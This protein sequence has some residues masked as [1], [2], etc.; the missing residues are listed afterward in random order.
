M[1]KGDGKH[2]VVATTPERSVQVAVA[3]YGTALPHELAHFVVERALGL[4][5]GF[6][7][8]LAAGADFAAV[9]A[10]NARSPKTVQAPTDPLV[11]AHLDELL[12]AERLVAELYQLG[13]GA[14]D[15]HGVD[16]AQAAGIR[17]EI[18]AL[19]ALWQDLPVGDALRLTWT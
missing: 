10:F 15:E 9:M 3:D 14:T 2:R 7:G 11:A 1:V 19:N 16:P 4:R 13:A 17:E 6:W 8:L 12:E 18:D 5:H